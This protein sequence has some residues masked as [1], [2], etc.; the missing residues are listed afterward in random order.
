MEC[1]RLLLIVNS[2]QCKSHILEEFKA[3][4]RVLHQVV[5]LFLL[6][7]C[8]RKTIEFRLSVHYN[9]LKDKPFQVTFVLIPLEGIA[10]DG[11]VEVHKNILIG[12]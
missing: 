11:I 4:V 10:R 3:P 12:S 8:P 6:V 5:H 2:L 1:S 9:L 7:V